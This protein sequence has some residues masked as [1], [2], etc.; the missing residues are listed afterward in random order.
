MI[1]SKPAW[2]L[3]FNLQVAAEEAQMIDTYKLDERFLCDYINNDGKESILVVG[4]AI[5]GK[6]GHVFFDLE[7]ANAM[8]VSLIQ[9]CSNFRE[10]LR[11]L[12]EIRA[13]GGVQ[14]I[15]FPLQEPNVPPSI[16]AAAQ[17][18]SQQAQAPS[19]AA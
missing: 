4:Q 3:F 6:G 19:S 14:V 13:G 11:Q 8:K 9:G 18:A 1:K 15:D 7:R 16:L 17:S 12:H 5:K 2:Q 10:Y